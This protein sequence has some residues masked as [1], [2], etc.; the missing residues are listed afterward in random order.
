[1]FI[2]LSDYIKQRRRQ[3]GGTSSGTFGTMK[4]QNDLEQFEYLAFFSTT[5]GRIFMIKK[6]EDNEDKQ[7]AR[8]DRIIE[9]HDPVIY[10]YP[11]ERGL[12]SK[13]IKGG[14]VVLQMLQDRLPDGFQRGLEIENTMYEKYRA[15]QFLLMNISKNKK[16]LES[17]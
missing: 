13:E 10:K 3:V 11:N 15:D 12:D 6:S 17:S 9:R 7:S 2:A 8:F 4:S 1:M 16:S 5:S 14:L